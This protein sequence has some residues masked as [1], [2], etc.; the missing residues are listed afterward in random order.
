MRTTQKYWISVFRPIFE[1]TYS[2]AFHFVVKPNRSFASFISGQKGLR[3]FLF[4]FNINSPFLC[5]LFESLLNCAPAHAL[6][7]DVAKCCLLRIH[8]CEFILNMASSSPYRSCPLHNKLM[9]S[10]VPLE[11][12]ISKF[13]DSL[14]FS[15]TSP[16]ECDESTNS[17]Q[18]RPWLNYYLQQIVTFVGGNRYAQKFNWLRYGLIGANLILMRCVCCSCFRLLPFAETFARNIILSANSAVFTCAKL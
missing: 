8:T 16:N 5:R 7:E 9:Y 1:M 6:P 11:Q 10:H 18:F 3:F 12:N 14:Y 4:T 13:T 15:G 2:V 17:C